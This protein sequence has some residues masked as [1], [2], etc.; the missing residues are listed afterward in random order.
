MQGNVK[1][2]LGASKFMIH[3]TT[4]Y[5]DVIFHNEGHIAIFCKSN[6]RIK[7]RL[8]NLRK[9]ECFNLILTIIIPV[10]ELMKYLSNAASRVP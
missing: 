5:N 8:K 10:K 7:R 4:I 2:L 6:H 9:S 3:K 1:S